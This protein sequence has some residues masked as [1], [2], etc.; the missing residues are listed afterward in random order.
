M[1]TLNLQTP[2]PPFVASPLAYREVIPQSEFT[3]GS[4]GV[5][6]MMPD[7]KM[8]AVKAWNIGVQR[9]IAKNTVIEVRY[10]GNK[11]SNVWHTYNLN[12]VNTIENG[13]AEEFKLAQQNLAINVA[14]GLT[15]FANN[16]LA[17]Q[18]ALPIL[19][20]AFGARGSQAALPANQG[21]TNAGFITNLQQG[22]AGPDGGV[23]RREPDVL[24]PHGRQH[25]HALLDRRPQL[26]RARTV[27]DQLLPGE[28]VRDRR[29]SQHRA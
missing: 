9:L 3:F 28:S 24:L 16:G 27:P 11:G 29:Q 13:F 8:G 18:R 14:N 26:Q 6:A 4:T 17:G 10:V 23:D 5:N 12:E 2:L 20:A 7:L 15:G 1:G 19:D 22:E 21:Y 25:V